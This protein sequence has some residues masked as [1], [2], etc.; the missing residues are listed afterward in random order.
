MAFELGLKARAAG[1]RLVEYETVGSTNTEALAWATLGDPGMLWVVAE[2]QSAG[3][4]RRGSK[5]ETPRGNL[6]AS[7]LILRGKASTP[8]A[9]MGFVAGLALEQAIRTA[10]PDLA[11]KTVLDGVAEGSDRV[12]LKWPNDVLFDGA[13]VAGI[14]LEAVT[15]A[16]GRQSVVVGI[17]VNV[18]Q[19][20]SGI[21]YPVTSLSACG[22]DVSPHT[23]FT[24][25]SEAW[26]EQFG[27]W[28]EGDGFAAIRNRWLER[29]AGLGRP[30]AVKVGAEVYR[31]T[32]ETIDRE[33]RMIVRAGDGSSHA[34]TAGEVHFGAAAT[35]GH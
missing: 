31:G 21:S 22:A 17:G 20:P 1:Y 2:E 33:G 32:F 6:A 11:V 25:L 14:L 12:T 29:A 9:P 30:I 24:A 13:K 3:H 35:V 34:I 7:L 19:A 16:D 10:A 18:R 23:L 4:G 5:W 28:N 15:L 26:L 27:L 8:P